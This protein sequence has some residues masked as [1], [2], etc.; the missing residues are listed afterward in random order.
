VLQQTAFLAAK[1]V[2]VEALQSPHPQA[3]PRA[4]QVGLAAVVAAVAA[5]AT[6]P[7]WAARAVLVAMDIAS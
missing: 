4:E 2:A 5:P 7:A 3:G 6:T 1:V